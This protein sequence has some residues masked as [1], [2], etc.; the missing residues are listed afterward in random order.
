M[1]NFQP[2]A[3][4]TIITFIICT[5]ANLIFYFIL[6]LEQLNQKPV[7]VIEKAY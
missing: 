7:E 4:D 3:E 6:K 2:D 1:N 5:F